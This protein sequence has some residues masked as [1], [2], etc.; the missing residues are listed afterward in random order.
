[1]TRGLSPNASNRMLTTFE[2]PQCGMPFVFQ[3]NETRQD[4]AAVDHDLWLDTCLDNDVDRTRS[5]DHDSRHCASQT[6]VYVQEV[7]SCLQKS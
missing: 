3:T 6:C 4:F 1:M 7:A 2:C 5:K